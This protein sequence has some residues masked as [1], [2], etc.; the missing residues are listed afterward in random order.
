MPQTPQRRARYP[1]DWRIIATSVKDQAA[2]CCE[3][4]GRP[5][6]PLNGH[7]LTVHHLDNTPENNQWYNLVALCL[8]CHAKIA[9]HYTPGQRTFD[10]YEP[11]AWMAERGLVRGA[12]QMAFWF[13][14]PGELFPRK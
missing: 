14:G 11:P 13:Y 5:H 6:D 1:A 3:H 12:R 7:P 10:F 9:A 2:W 4:C 8:P